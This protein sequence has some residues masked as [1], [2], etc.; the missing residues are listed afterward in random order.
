MSSNP[1]LC[2]PRSIRS[3]Q[4]ISPLWKAVYASVFFRFSLNYCAALG[5]TSCRPYRASVRRDIHETLCAE[6]VD[7]FA[8]YDRHC[9]AIRLIRRRLGTA[10]LPGGGT[11]CGWSFCIPS[12]PATSRPALLQVI[13]AAVFSSS[14]CPRRI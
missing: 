13:S 8:K 7:L 3:A 2:K 4:S 14:G 9:P 10:M 5:N 1:A 12:L 6:P 11:A